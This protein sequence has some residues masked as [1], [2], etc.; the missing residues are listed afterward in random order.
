MGEDGDH[1]LVAERAFSRPQI[2]SERP[3]SADMSGPRKKH[4]APIAT[5]MEPLNSLSWASIKDTVSKC[6]EAD[7]RIVVGASPV[8]Q[9]HFQ[10]A[11]IIP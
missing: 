9:V 10:Q 2:C 6:S 4:F 1:A 3:T 7:R 5:V 8:V 11:D